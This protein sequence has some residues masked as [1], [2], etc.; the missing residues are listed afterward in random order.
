MEYDKDFR[1]KKKEALLQIDEWCRN[2]MRDSKV[3]SV[4]TTICCNDRNYAVSATKKGVSAVGNGKFS[5]YM[6][7]IDGSNSLFDQK[8]GTVIITQWQSIKENLIRAKEKE[9]HD[10]KAVMEFV[11]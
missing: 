10:R 9:E 2:L 1:E 11:I 5:Q 6:H 4:K 3:S 8:V 7:A